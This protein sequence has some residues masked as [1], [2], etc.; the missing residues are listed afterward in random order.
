MPVVDPAAVVDG[1][2]VGDVEDMG[3]KVEPP[4]RLSGSSPRGVT[5]WAV[6]GAV[7]GAGTGAGPTK[8]GLGIFSESTSMML[9]S[10]APSPSH[11]AVLLAS[12]AAKSWTCQ[13]LGSG[14]ETGKTNTWTSCTDARSHLRPRKRSREDMLWELRKNKSEKYVL[15][16]ELHLDSPRR[17]DIS[18]RSNALG[19]SSIVGREVFLVWLSVPIYAYLP[20][21][22]IPFGR[23]IAGFKR[24]DAISRL[25][26]SS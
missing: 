10:R 9:W 2:L 13:H 8:I 1:A 25:A 11:V 6:V 15:N 19:E 20:M 12:A 5:G 14:A 24:E 22:R 23:P 26:I 17:E 16:E 3:A 7:A 21:L 4:L 18:L